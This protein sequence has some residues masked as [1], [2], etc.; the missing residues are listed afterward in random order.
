MM[1]HLHVTG[2]NILVV[3]LHHVGK[4]GH[5]VGHPQAPMYFDGLAGKE[6]VGAAASHPH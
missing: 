2:C 5:V 6:A 1:T 3:V 4:E